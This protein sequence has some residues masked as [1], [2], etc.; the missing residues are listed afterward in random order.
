MGKCETKIT[1]IEFIIGEELTTATVTVK[2]IGDCPLSVQ[3]AHTKAFPPSR[4]VLSI[5][6]EEIANGEY[7]L[8]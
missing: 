6:Q 5:L 4:S 3:G 1:G 2:A 8:W 7:L